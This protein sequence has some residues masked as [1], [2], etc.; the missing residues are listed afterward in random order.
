MNKSLIILLILS[1]SGLALYQ[2]TQKTADEI[3]DSYET[4]LDQELEDLEQGSLI[5]RADD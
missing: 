5:F 3:Y 4:E 1:I 2:F